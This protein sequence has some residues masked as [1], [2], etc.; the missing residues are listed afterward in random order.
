MDQNTFQKGIQ[1]NKPNRRYLKKYS[2]IHSLME[3]MLVTDPRTRPSCSELLDDPI[4]KGY[5]TTP[6][7]LITSKLGDLKNY[8]FDIFD[9][10]ARQDEKS[11]RYY[12]TALALFRNLQGSEEKIPVK[13]G[14]RACIS[15]AKKILGISN[16]NTKEFLEN[17]LKVCK[18]L[19]Y[20]LV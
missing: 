16:F 20:K 9:I 5:T 8:E 19:D 4:F 1:Y 3:R 12:D 15:L 2:K 7:T 6:F 10:E 11:E 13:D 17:E 18:I 14:S